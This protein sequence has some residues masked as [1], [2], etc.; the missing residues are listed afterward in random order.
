MKLI[1]GLGNPG[2]NYARNRHNAGFQCLNYIARLHS[3]RL[4]RRQCHARVGI[5]EVTGEK[6][7]LA[8]PATFVNLSGQSIACL[9]RKHSVSL[10]DLLVIYDD[11]DLPL[12]KIRLRQS[13]SSGG[14]KGMN[15]IISALD[16]EDFPRIRVGIGRP[17]AEKQS[18]SEDTV[19]SYVLSNFTPAEEAIIK[20]AIAKVAE[21][22]DCFLT[23]G[24]K[25]A[26]N[27]FN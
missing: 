1:V 9:M 19:V 7:L 22:I 26:M 27:K 6:L 24:T 23:E 18:M 16:S 25:A 17:Q 4:D 13:G 15:S 14:H 5:G 3:I 8:R 21:A 10:S 12:G 2:K 20:P 11:L